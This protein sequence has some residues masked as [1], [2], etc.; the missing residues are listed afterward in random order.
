MLQFP[1]VYRTSRW[2]L[3]MVGVGLAISIAG[4]W[5]FRQRAGAVVETIGLG[6]LAALFALGIVEGLTA[7]VV[8]G[9]ERLDI[10]SNFRRTSVARSEVVRAVGEKGVPVAIQLR[11]GAWLK[12]PTLGTGP[13]ANTLR[14]WIRSGSPAGA[15]DHRD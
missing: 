2:L 14:A 10:L 15:G 8:L 5:I 11:S 13:H 6:A 1:I 3:A 12:L 4:V 7:R 9:V